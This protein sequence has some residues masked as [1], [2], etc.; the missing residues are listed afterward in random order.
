[1]KYEENLLFPTFPLYKQYT[2][3]L[4]DFIYQSSLTSKK[5]VRIQE[6]RIKQQTQ[7][8]HTYCSISANN[9]GI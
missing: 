3:G 6:D 7:D 1:M 8:Q 2:L 5:T 9:V 4:L